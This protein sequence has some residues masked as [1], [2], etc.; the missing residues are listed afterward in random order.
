MLQTMAT[1][2]TTKDVAEKLVQLCKS[3]NFYEAVTTLY[4]DDVVSVEAMAG[5]DGNREIKGLAAVKAKSEWWAANH[6]VHSHAVEGPL[7]AGRQFCVKFILD[8]T[9]KPESRRMHMEELAIYE[10]KDGKIV[11]EEFF[12]LM[13]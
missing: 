11:R 13:G 7:V 10:A 8:V 2:M 1:E 5:P 9:F 3:G 12:Y 6:E 4:A